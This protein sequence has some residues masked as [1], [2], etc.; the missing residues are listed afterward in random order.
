MR[1]AS[2]CCRSLVMQDWQ[3]AKQQAA[4]LKQRRA[5]KSGQ[6]DITSVNVEVRVLVSP[7][8][9]RLG[10]KRTHILR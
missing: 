5:N 10:A 7:S 6:R 9:S 2:E 8:R 3:V 4:A 1:A